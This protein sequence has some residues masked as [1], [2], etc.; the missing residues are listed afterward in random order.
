MKNRVG[1]LNPLQDF[2]RP[3]ADPAG[4]CSGSSVMIPIAMRQ[5]NIGG[6]DMR[7]GRGARRLAGSATK[8]SQAAAILVTGVN[9]GAAS[10]AGNS[11]AGTGRENR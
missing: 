9:R 2:R 5:R 8:R 7:G 10:I 4:S 11:P 6:G 3:R 1:T